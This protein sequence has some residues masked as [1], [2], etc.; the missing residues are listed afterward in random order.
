MA[1]THAVHSAF[2][3]LAVPAVAE[4]ALVHEEDALAPVAHAIPAIPTT[5]AGTVTHGAAAPA[6]HAVPA[7]H[8]VE[9]EAFPQFPQLPPAPQFAVILKVPFCVSVPFI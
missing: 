5:H 6:L 7:V 1:V 4:D 9:P 2:A 3:P 8:H